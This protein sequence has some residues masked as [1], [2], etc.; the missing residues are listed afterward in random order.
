MQITLIVW[1]KFHDFVFA[2]I[3][4]FRGPDNQQLIILRITPSHNYNAYN[5]EQN[6]KSDMQSMDKVVNDIEFNYHHPFPQ[7]VQEYAMNT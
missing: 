3:L 1:W 2:A 7:I 5:Q 6:L 4:T